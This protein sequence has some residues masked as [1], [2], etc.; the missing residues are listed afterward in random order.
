MSVGTCGIYE[1]IN[2]WTKIMLQQLQPQ[3]LWL[4]FEPLCWL[5][6]ACLATEETN[7]TVQRKKLSAALG[8][9]EQ[10]PAQQPQQCITFSCGVATSMQ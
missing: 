7:C 3:P 2:S 9:M 6:V 10:G 8:P 4:L 5:S 1:V